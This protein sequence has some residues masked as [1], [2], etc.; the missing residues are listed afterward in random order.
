MHEMY[1]GA[2]AECQEAGLLP[3]GNPIMLAALTYATAHG[4]VDLALSGQAKEEK[5]PGIPWSSCCCSSGT[6]EPLEGNPL[7][8]A[9]VYP[10][11]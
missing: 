11:A 2:V 6:C 8:A 3:A 5:G 10:C 7:R 1:V 4:A 9:G